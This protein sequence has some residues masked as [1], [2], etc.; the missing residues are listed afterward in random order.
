MLNV[1]ESRRMG[2]AAK[3]ILAT[4][5][6][7]AAAPLIV[8]QAQSSEV[9]IKKK[10]D[11]GSAAGDS[12]SEDTDRVEY[13]LDFAAE[14]ARD[15]SAA[16][17]LRQLQVQGPPAP[18]DSLDREIEVLEIYIDD[19]G[20][21][22]EGQ[23]G[24]SPLDVRVSD[25]DEQ[26]EQDQWDQWDQWDEW[27]ECE[28]ERVVKCEGP[29]RGQLDFE[30]DFGY[31]RVDG[32]SI[33]L[34]QDLDHHDWRV[35][36]I[37]LNE[38]YSS[39]QDKW[40][41]EVG[42]E[43]RLL[44][45]V[46]LYVGASVYKITDSN[47]QDKEII[48]DRENTLAAFFL[49]E[50][51]RD[52]FTRNGSTLH[53][54][55]DLPAHSSIKVEYLDD[56][57][58]SLERRADWSLFRGSTRFRPNPEIAEGDMNSFIASYTLDTVRDARCSP[59]GALVRLAVEKAGGDLG[60]DFDF[61]TV[62]FDARNYVKLS[63][64]QF[65]RYRLKLGS[66]T[67]GEFPRR[68]DPIDGRT[69]VFQKEFYVGGIGTLRGH[70]YKALTGDQMILGSVE[71]GVY[72]GRDLGLFVFVDSGKAWYGDG[73]FAEQRLELDAGVGVELFCHETQ[74]YA[75]KNVK[76]PDSP[77]LVGLRLNRTF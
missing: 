4:A 63:P 42:I 76:D 39:K 2:R 12:L 64:F 72:T 58:T 36:R 46:P 48:G 40:F 19:E 27:D 17:S 11:T 68:S 50:D 66:R 67:Q 14:A 26:E 73:G 37:R 13:Y 33:G 10:A 16:D 71:Y 32:L 20:V 22:I 53:A 74:I 35:P 61:T 5:L 56:S 69:V 43:Q 34:E 59:S 45:F 9:V 6:V 3:T 60:G 44:H 49:K 21:R 70:D 30:M 75:A 31:Q 1:W 18:P 55:L 52:Y 41:Y 54:K 38:I 15:S 25:W 77:V 65:L 47:P 7:L 57:Y 24:R 62:T 28:K 8:G 23:R 29:M 51:Y